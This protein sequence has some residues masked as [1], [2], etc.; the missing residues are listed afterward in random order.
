LSSYQI[1]LLSFGSLRRSKKLKSTSTSDDAG[2][3]A[4][5][6]VAAASKGEKNGKRA[7]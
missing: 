3:Q 1:F 4:A 7:R 5:R 6:E 2:R